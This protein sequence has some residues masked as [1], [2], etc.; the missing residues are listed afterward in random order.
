MDGPNKGHPMTNESKP[1]ETLGQGGRE[2]I[3]NLPAAVLAL[4]AAMVAVHLAKTFI[5]NQEGEVSL[6][7]WFAFVPFRFLDPTNADGGLWPLIWTPVTHAFL[8]GSWEHLIFNTLWLAIFG[9][10]VARRYGTVPFL[11]IFLVSAIAGAALYAAYALIVQEP[12]FLLGASGGVAGLTGAAVRFMFQPVIVARHPETGE[13]VPLGRRLASLR[14]LVTNSQTRFFILIWVIL[15]GVVP[16]LPIGDMQIA[17]H[18]HLA[19]FFTGLLIVPL[20]ERRPA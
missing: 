16:L 9:T 4:C 8:H 19:G 14:D 7:V 13:A 15:N 12:G 10:P 6:L 5:L 20:F 2:P 3:F 1:E 17:W 18:A 11:T